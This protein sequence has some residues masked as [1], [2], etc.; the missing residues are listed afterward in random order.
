MQM[1]EYM[2]AEEYDSAAR[3][4]RIVEQARPC[5]HGVYGIVMKEKQSYL[6]YVLEFPK[7]PGI[8][9]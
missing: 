7:I 8:T 2:H 3:G 9:Y 6:A 4:H 5:G 1:M